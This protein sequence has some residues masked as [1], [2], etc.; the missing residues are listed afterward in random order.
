MLTTLEVATDDM[1]LRVPFGHIL[2]WSEFT[3]YYP[4][5]KEAMD[6]S[7]ETST[8]GFYYYLN[9]VNQ[10]YEFHD[11]DAENDIAECI[12]M[13]LDVISNGEEDM[14]K[15]ERDRAEKRRIEERSM[16]AFLHLETEAERN[17]FILSDIDI[18]S[19]LAA[20]A[21]P[22]SKE[23]RKREKKERRKARVHQRDGDGDGDGEDI[24]GKIQ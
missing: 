16:I 11:E 14:E 13:R 23:E 20:L 18:D 17:D 19:Y 2:S 5:I 1:Q 4:G 15:T 12:G 24:H 21:K 22:L 10:I 3:Q 9:P 7:D 8:L 6:G